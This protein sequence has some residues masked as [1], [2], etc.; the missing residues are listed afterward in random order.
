M[1]TQTETRPNFN[2]HVNACDIRLLAGLIAVCGDEVC[3]GA[4]EYALANLADLNVNLIR[5]EI[6]NQKRLS[7]N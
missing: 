5:G 1:A 4:Y 3:Q 2:D 6:A 7:N